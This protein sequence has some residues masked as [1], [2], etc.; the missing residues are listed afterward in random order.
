MI[1]A[2]L[3]GP[4]LIVVAI[5]V[6]VLFALGITLRIVRRIEAMLPAQGLIVELPQ[7]RLHVLER[8]ASADPGQ[9]VLLL[10]HGLAG[11]LGHFSYQLVDELART[12]RVIAIDRPGSGYSSWRSTIEPTFDAQ[13]QVIGALIEALA[14]SRVLLVGH[15]LGGAVALATALRHREQVA[16]LALLAPLTQ[17]PEE[18]PKVF[19]GLLAGSDGLRWLLAWTL[20]VPIG[21]LQRKRL[22]RPIFAPDPVPVDYGVRAGGELSLRPAHFMAAARDLATVPASLD[23]LIARYPAL[24]A[25]PALPISVLFGR[26]DRILAASLHGEAFARAMPGVRLELID[27]GHMLPI[28]Q[29]QVCADFI[30]RSA[31]QLAGEPWPTRQ[32]IAQ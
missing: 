32:R 25:D 26:Q 29:P 10:I 1:S 31:A 20:V 18:V 28:V 22:L 3:A 30:R 12:H 8:G 16:G 23:A 24:A 5:A 14:L 9:P 2:A 27:A 13:A 4:V 6:L 17:R 7:A 15:S 21:R 19:R 11:Q